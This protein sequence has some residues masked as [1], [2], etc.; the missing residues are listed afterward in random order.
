MEALASA[1]DTELDLGALD[2]YLPEL[3]RGYRTALK[4]VET[5]PGSFAT[6]PVLRYTLQ[7]S[8]PADPAELKRSISS[9]NKRSRRLVSRG[10]VG[11]FVDAHV[12]AKLQDILRLLSIERMGVLADEEAAKKLD[13]YIKEIDQ[14]LKMLSERSRSRFWLANSPLVSS[15]LAFAA[16][17]LI[18]LVGID[19]SGSA[20][21]GAS[22]SNLVQSQGVETLIHIVWFVLLVLLYLYIIFAP[23]AVTF[24]FRV[25]RAIFSGG[26]SEENVFDWRPVIHDRDIAYWPGLP[27]LNIYHLETKLF[28][29]FGAAKKREFPLDFVLSILPYFTWTFAIIY[30]VAVSSALISGKSPGFENVC[31]LLAFW[32]LSVTSVIGA[33]RNYRMRKADGNL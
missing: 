10:L 16:P 13:F 25:K 30:T 8:I 23:V 32:F 19:I 7:G 11:L 1:H 31:A 9:R 14:V 6:L 12:R 33:V 27:T 24:G 21:L 28:E 20:A 22:V 26:F 5:L 2:S 29:M 17:I 15:L 4:S 3:I 18:G